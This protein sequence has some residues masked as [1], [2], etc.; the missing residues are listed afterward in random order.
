MRGWNSN[1]WG[2]WNKIFAGLCVVLALALAVF[3]FWYMRSERENVQDLVEKAMKLGYKVGMY[4]VSED[5]F[6]DMGEFAEMKRM[7]EKLNLQ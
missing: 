6:L 7:E 3:L 2:F 1:K 5:S 4:P